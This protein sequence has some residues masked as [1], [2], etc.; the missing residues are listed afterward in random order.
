MSVNAAISRLWHSPTVTTWGSLGV[1]MASVIVL[2][3]VVLVRFPP[4]EVAVW[5][6]M[7]VLFMLGLML[8]FALAPTFTRLLS[9]ARAGVPTTEMGR[10]APTPAAVSANA[11]DAAAAESLGAV[12]GTMRW[13]YIRIALAMTLLLVVLGSWALM[14]PIGQMADGTEAWMAWGIVVVSFGF[15]LWGGCFSA[16]LQGMDNIAELRRWEMLFG[17]AQVATSVVVLVSGGGLLALLAASQ[18]W[19]VIGVARNFALLRRRHPRLSGA[20]TG[21]TPA[22]MTAAAGPAWRSLVGVLCSMGLI[23]MSAVYYGQVLP[24]GELAAYLLGLRLITMVSQFSQAPFYTKIPGMANAYGAGQTSVVLQSARVGMQ[25]AHWAFVIGALSAAVAAPWVLTLVQSRTVFMPGPVF[26]VLAFAFWLE[27]LGAMHIQ[28]YS[29]TN[30]VVWHIANGATAIIVLTA[31]VVLTSSA[32][33][34][35]FPIAM[36][37]GYAAF[38]CPFSMRKSAVAFGLRL[39]SFERGVSF[40]PG[41]VLLAGLALSILLPPPR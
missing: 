37:L 24:A 39:R 12:F 19:V 35:A 40:A 7:S 11:G 26:A 20:A 36:L 18:T 27:R 1:R 6:L 8:D 21:A 16:T 13:L 29:L 34:L 3:P 9:Y 5:Q 10:P 31:T 41:A 33:M 2:L 30:H 23:Q 14:K 4:E 25:R 17:L 28:L 32:G 38:Y 22:V 15:A